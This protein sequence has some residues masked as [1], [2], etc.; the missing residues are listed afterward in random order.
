MI[1]SLHIIYLISIFYIISLWVFWCPACYSGLAKFPVPPRHHGSSLSHLSCSLL[2]FSLPLHASPYLFF[3]FSLFF[4]FVSFLAWVYLCGCVCTFV[5]GDRCL[6]MGMCVETKSSFTLFFVSFLYM[7]MNYV[8][9]CVCLICEGVCVC[10]YLFMRTD[11]CVPQCMCGDQRTTLVLLV[12]SHIFWVI[13]SFLCVVHHC[14]A[15][16][17]IEHWDFS[18]TLLYPALC[19]F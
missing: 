10:L 7:W 11:T 3:S 19:G 4:L 1:S 18:C 12:I 14:V 15:W 9:V 17:A 2:S 5:F 6:Y 16:L 8:R 13:V